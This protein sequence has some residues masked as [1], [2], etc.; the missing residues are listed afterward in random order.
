MER[1]LS[2]SIRDD[3]EA[4]LRKA[5]KELKTD[6]FGFGFSFYRKY[7]K[8]WHKEYEQKWEDIFPELPVTVHVDAKVI[9]T[10]VTFRRFIF[11]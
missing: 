5:Q 2:D 1:E 6:I 10:G 9:N 8:L 11:K 3:I 4:S 7:P